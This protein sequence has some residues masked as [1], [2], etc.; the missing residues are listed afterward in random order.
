MLQEVRLTNGKT[1]P[2]LLVTTLTG[3]LRGLLEDR[4]QDGE[5]ARAAADR[6]RNMLA[7]YEL[8]E[9]S[10]NPAHK[11]FSEPLFAR[12][13]GLHLV[14]GT[15]ESP[16]VQGT[17]RDIVTAC[18]VTTPE[19]GLDFTDPIKRDKAGRPVLASE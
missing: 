14:G 4:T 19:G 10:K 16:R 3:I 8:S 5:D 11:V 15:Y 12:L 18:L 2:M 9:L 17:V 13:Q 7:L 6:L 1:A